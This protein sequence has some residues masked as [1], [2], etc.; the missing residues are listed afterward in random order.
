MQNL[1]SI[2][3]EECTRLI[4]KYY[5]KDEEENQKPTFYQLNSF[6]NVLF[7]QLKYLCGNF[8]LN[9]GQLEK[10][11]IDFSCPEL[12]KIRSYIIKSLIKLSKYCTKSAYDSLLNSQNE[13]QNYYNEEESLKKAN[14]YLTNKKIISFDELLEKTNIIFFN[15]DINSMSIITKQKKNSKEY[16]NLFQLYNSGNLS[17]DKKTKKRK[18][19]YLIDYSKLTNEGFL[20]EINKVLALYYTNEELKQRIGNY[21]FTQ[22]NFIKLILIILKIRAKVPIIMM[23]ETG[24]GKTS[25]I[26]VIS[27]LKNNIILILKIHA[28][29]TNEDIIKFIEDNNLYQ[30]DNKQ[31]NYY[32][33]IWIFLDE[34]NTCNSMGLISEMMCKGTIQGKKLIENCI[35]IA[36][37]NPYRKYEKKIEEIGL[38]SKLTKKKK[39]SLFSKSFTILFV[40]FCF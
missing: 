5:N 10:A 14:E 17:K 9:A 12:G 32:E 24:C 4:K 23:G 18:M 6:I 34:I 28:G 35:F 27:K 40:K 15:E 26:N 8:Y 7:E 37:C 2:D 25:L 21:V 33:K 3:N 38:V 31:N 36:A 13:F 22:D 16:Q 39:F 20:D 29:I 11:S 1:I 19:E 30:L